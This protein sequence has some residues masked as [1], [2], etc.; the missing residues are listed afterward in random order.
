MHSEFYYV[1][2]GL[3]I[4]NVYMCL[5][6]DRRG[7]NVLNAWPLK[8]NRNSCKGLQSSLGDSCRCGMGHV[9]I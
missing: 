5:F 8:S 4:D 1:G 6:Q 2:G 9:Q 3:Y 7:I